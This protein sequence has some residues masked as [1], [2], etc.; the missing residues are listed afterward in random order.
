M[1]KQNKTLLFIYHAMDI[2]GIET[3][4]IRLIRELRN[5][6]NRILW[7]CPRDRYIDE[8]FKN[9]LLDGYVELIEINKS[10]LN[11]IKHADIPFHIGE[12]VIALA[13]DLFDFMRIE[14]I[15][16]EYSKIQIDSFYW[17]PHF[18][19][20]NRFIEEQASRPFQ[21]IIRSIVGRIIKNME[22]NDNIYYLSKSHLAAYTSKYGYKVRDEKKKISSG[23]TLEIQPYDYNLAL[24]RSLRNEFNIITVGR[25]DF[26]HKAYVLGLIKAFAELKEK[27][28][29]IKLT[30][31][32]YG[33]D[34][35]KVI[36]QINQLPDDIKKDINLVGKVP[37]NDLR[38]YFEKAHLNIGV[39]ST[40]SDAAVKGLISIPVRHYSEKCEGYGY[41]PDSRDKITTDVPGVPIQEFIKEVITMS[42]EKYLELSKKAYDTYASD[43][44][45]SNIM[46]ILEC[47]NKDAYKTVSNRTIIFI[48]LFRVLTG[49][50]RRISRVILNGRIKNI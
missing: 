47:R 29:W 40:I 10:G 17:V 18:F 19:G 37:Y 16:K 31:V 5:N 14:T 42:Q 21:H 7:L 9:D 46:S 48:R 2:G 12:E 24:K 41:L 22:Q 6:G 36:Q 11:W 50:K 20:P 23:T 38:M 1:T 3:Y 26:P 39:A 25:F 35:D 15:K 34:E 32:G 49:S 30:I 45:T 27:Y 44:T 13:F 8:S 28:G 43:G 33:K 4:L